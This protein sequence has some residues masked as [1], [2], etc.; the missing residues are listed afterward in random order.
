MGGLELSTW[1]RVGEHVLFRLVREVTPPR[2][3]SC[4]A[5]G[6]SDCMLPGWVLAELRLGALSPF[7]IKNG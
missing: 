6:P 4:R 2:P 3:G 1:V 5:Q 7:R